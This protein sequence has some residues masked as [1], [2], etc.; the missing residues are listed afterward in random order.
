MRLA[1]VTPSNKCDGPVNTS[2][3]WVLNACSGANAGIRR[4]TDTA[5]IGNMLLPSCPRRK[6][7]VKLRKL[8]LLQ[9]A[10]ADRRIQLAILYLFIDERAHN[11]DLDSSRGSFR[12]ID[13]RFFQFLNAIFSLKSYQK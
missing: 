13:A 7:R 9:L 4:V 11:L 12:G 1:R 6:H 10:K 2:A 5:D 8:S 3:K